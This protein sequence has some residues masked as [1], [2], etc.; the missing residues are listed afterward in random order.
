VRYLGDLHGGQ[1]LRRNIA[2]MLQISEEQGVHFYDFGPSQRVKELIQS[3]R[4]GLN[5]LALDAGQ[6]DAMA[7]EARLGFDLH[8][9]MFE[10]LPH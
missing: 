6:G 8:I 1:V 4:A 2:R 3:F 9:Q 10:Q 7:Q 5:S